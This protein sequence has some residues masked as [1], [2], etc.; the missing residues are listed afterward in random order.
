MATFLKPGEI[1]IQAGA[2]ALRAPDG[3]RLEAVPQYIIAG[4]DPGAASGDVAAYT[5]ATLQAGE[6]LV[7]VG[8]VHSAREAAEARYAAALAGRANP[9]ADGTPLYIKEAAANMG[10]SGLSKSEEKTA[11]ELIDDLIT[12]YT[13]VQEAGSNP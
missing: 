6:H 2:T 10:K 12:I 3:K 9:C 7:T 11:D 13:Q 1:L 8:T 5:V 4:I